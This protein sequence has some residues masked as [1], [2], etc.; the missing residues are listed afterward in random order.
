MAEKNIRDFTA[1]DVDDAL[2]A[3]DSY[4][5]FS[6]VPIDEESEAL[7]KKLFE[8]IKPIKGVIDKE[9]WEF[10]VSVP[11][12]TLEEFEKEYG[13][14]PNWTADEIKSEYHL[15]YP[16]PVKWYRLLFIHQ[17]DGRRGDYYV[18]GCEN[19]VKITIN[20]VNQNH[21]QIPVDASAWIKWLIFKIEQVI[22][23]LKNGTY[24]ENVKNNLPAKL[25]YGKIL[26][27]DYWDIYTE[28]RE[29]Y[30]ERFAPGLI[31]EFLKYAENF[32]AEE[33]Y[34][35]IPENALKAMTA[36]DFYEACAVGYEAA[37]Y[38]G[39]SLRFED[40][41]EE[42]K[43]YGVT[44]DNGKA[45][46]KELY[47]RYADGRDN[48]LGNV[49]MDDPEA[50]YEWRQE[51]GP[52]FQM[53]GNHPWEI[54]GSWSLRDSIH[55]YAEIEE[56]DGDRKGYFRLS[57]DTYGTAPET[58]AFYVALRKAGYPVILSNGIE[59]AARLSET[60]YIGIIPDDLSSMAVKYGCDKFEEDI[61]DFVHLD[62]GDK[63][64]KV[65]EKA[66][67]LDIEPLYL[68]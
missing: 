8:I 4:D 7:V 26:R 37:G 46:P 41:E 28:D 34:G 31:E 59:I 18:I 57:G 66:E 62:E 20:D 21:D 2:T 44:E 5:V 61:I 43:R 50:F 17:E 3:L 1:Q 67:W 29:K 42:H 11:C 64:E 9:R 39:S 23:E 32:A 6:T 63:P 35:Y 13:D 53:T 22:E 25:K 56:V 49:P 58:I 36:R 55:L 33:D 14:D 45:T 38:K 30:L 52:Y 47:Y 40:S 68:T 12:G 19:T 65:I 10:W 51:K 15:L 48:G 60:D 16:D 27:K 24:N 54:R